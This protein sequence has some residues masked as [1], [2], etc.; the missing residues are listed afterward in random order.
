MDDNFHEVIETMGLTKM[1]LENAE[2]RMPPPL[3]KLP[4]EEYRIGNS[5]ID[6]TG[7]M[8]LGN[9]LPQ[10]KIA[11]L[12]IKG[13]WTEIG[14]FA[15]HSPS[16]NMVSFKNGDTLVAFASRSINPGDELTL[17]YLQVRESLK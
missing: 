15:N 9:F 12:N 8:S 14:R 4:N 13:D 6:R 17:D 16:P 3:P 11:T 2:K 7:V 10:D 1:D 5:K